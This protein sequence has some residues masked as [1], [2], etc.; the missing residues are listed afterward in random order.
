MVRA[1]VP[2]PQSI[3][4]FASDDPIKL[5]SPVSL[6]VAPV[7]FPLTSSFDDG[8]VVPM[9]ILPPFSIQNASPLTV[10]IVILGVPPEF[11]L[12]RCWNPNVF[13]LVVAPVYPLVPA[14]K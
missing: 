5:S 9:P 10:S 7:M 6:S 3:Y 4:L 13:Q 1:L 12:I 11:D 8:L 2:I 14:I